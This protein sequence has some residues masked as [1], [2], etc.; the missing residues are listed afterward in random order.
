MIQTLN[1][2]QPSVAAASSLQILCSYIN[3]TSRIQV[4][5]ITNVPNLRFEKVIFPGQRLLFKAMSEAKLEIQWS[6][7]TSKSIP[8]KH[9]Q[10]TE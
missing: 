2:S 9:L 7:L 6:E 1:A 8:C 5:R 3:V 4:I 10:V